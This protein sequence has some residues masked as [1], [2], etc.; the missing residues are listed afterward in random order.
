MSNRSVPFLQRVAQGTLPRLHQY[1]QR[2]PTPCMSSARTSLPSLGR[3]TAAL[4]VRS[5]PGAA[6]PGG[7]GFARG[8]RP[9]LFPW[10]M[11]GLPGSWEIPRPHAPLSVPGG[12][13]GPSLYGPFDIAFRN[14]HNVGSASI[15][16]LS[17]LNHA[18]YVLPVYASQPGSL[19]DHATLGSGWWLALAGMGL[20]PIGIS[21]EISI[22][23][24]SLPYPS[25]PGFAWR[26]QVTR[27]QRLS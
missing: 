18:A 1:Y 3:T 7:Q 10:N 12:P 25:P 4:W 9:L 6:P 24:S 11:Q 5:A 13:F 21:V 17:R 20:A 27:P 26:K 8:A 2:T 23:V 19:L 14:M 16:L 15:V 22:S